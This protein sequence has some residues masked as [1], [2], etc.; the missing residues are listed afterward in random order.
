MATDDIVDYLEYSLDIARR[1]GSE[2]VLRSCLFCGKSD[3]MYVN[4][5][6]M[7][8]NCFSASC[9]AGGSILRLVMAI[10]DCDRSEAVS[11][12]QRLSVGILRAKPASELLRL[13]EAF[14]S[15]KGL[16]AEAAAAVAIPLP[17]EFQP[18][19][20]GSSWSVPKFLTTK[21]VRRS[22]IKRWN[23]GFCQNGKYG[24]RVIVPVASAGLT[25]FVARDTTGLSERKYLNP[26]MALQGQMLFGYDSVSEESERVVAVEGVFD[27][28]ALWRY[29]YEAVAYF[30]S[31]L[32][33]EQV[34]MLSRKR[35]KEV[36]LM[37]DPDAL[38]AGA[39]SAGKLCAQFPSIRLAV[40]H[41][42]DPDE[43]G[44]AEVA[45]A[46]ES[47]RPVTGAATALEAML[48]AANNPWD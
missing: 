17:A 30:G 29:G 31:A 5:D 42:G 33:P 15:G 8:F 2:L 36:V 22:D 1:R 4:I 27:A 24:G 14:Q 41:G 28:I 38:R 35:V 45:R 40:I 10:E 21:R 18:C 44:M 16:D 34:A 43:I 39:E 26:G 37:P 13:F 20:S 3:K 46:I 23:I 11:I 47:A 19:W 9:G 48:M 32:R 12:L 7:K 6:K 25:S